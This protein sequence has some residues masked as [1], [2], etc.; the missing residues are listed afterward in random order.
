[1]FRGCRT[2]IGLATS[3]RHTVRPWTFSYDIHNGFYQTRIGNDS[4]LIH[5]FRSSGSELEDA[6][7]ACLNGA[8][9]ARRSMC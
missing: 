2:S 3:T 8:D 5:F 1:M 9:S 7:I 6:L 4:D